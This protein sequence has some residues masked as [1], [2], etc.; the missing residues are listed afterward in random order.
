MPNPGLIPVQPLAGFLHTLFL[1]LPFLS[2]KLQKEVQCLGH[3]KAPIYHCWPTQ[4][5]SLLQ[6]PPTWNSPR[7]LG[8]LEQ[9]WS[10]GLE[11]NWILLS[12]PQFPPLRGISVLKKM[13]VGP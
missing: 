5:H 6:T 4:P 10:G 8:L 9:L 3:P 2:G 13:E 1:S 12:V 7:V 11:S